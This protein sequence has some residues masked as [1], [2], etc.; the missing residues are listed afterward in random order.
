MYCTQN[1]LKEQSTFFGIFSKLKLIETSELSPYLDPH[2]VIV[3]TVLIHTVSV[4]HEG[5]ISRLEHQIRRSSWYQLLEDLGEE[6]GH[7]TECELD[8]FTLLLLQV[9]HEL[10]YLLLA[11]E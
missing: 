4:A 8:G 11:W 7:L 10:L 3:G 1:T 2:S 5:A 6:L 9:I